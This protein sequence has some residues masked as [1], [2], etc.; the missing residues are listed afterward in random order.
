MNILP[1]PAHPGAPLV[2]LSAAYWSR[3]KDL[4]AIVEDTT[5][6]L[7]ARCNAC[8]ELLETAPW[9]EFALLWKDR[10]EALLREATP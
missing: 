10:A 1:F 7:S 5:M 2:E 3:R 4:Q 8:S 6:P 9:P